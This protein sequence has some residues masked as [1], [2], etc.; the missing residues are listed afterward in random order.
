MTDAR[1]LEV[2]ASLT[3]TQITVG[4]GAEVNDFEN[5]GRGLSEAAVA[6]EAFEKFVQLLQGE[7]T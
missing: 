6:K 7:R 1:I 2:F 3:A 4:N 5:F